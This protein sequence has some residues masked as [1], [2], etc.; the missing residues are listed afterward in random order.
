[1][2]QIITDYRT[3]EDTK[4]ELKKLGFSVIDTKPIKALYTEVEGHGDMQ[5]H[6][7]NGKA[8]CEPTVYNYYLKKLKNVDVIC[9][10]V[11]INGKYPEDIAYNTCAIGNTAV[12]K[13]SNTAPEIINEYKNII[14]TRQGYAKCSLCVL[15]DYSVITSDNGLYK[16]LTN[17]GFN[18]LK[19]NPGH[20]ALGS[21]EGFIG[22][23][24][25]L[26]K[27]NLIAFNGDISE[28]PDYKNIKCFCR[29]LNIDIIS[30]KKGVLTDIGS[31]LVV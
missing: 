22:G 20:I 17:L 23:A 25:G 13:V 2:K 3:D 28:H 5:I 6:I 19:I 29:D 26:I 31:F 21:M 10:S 9:G 16:Q 4:A 12:C 27:P 11:A 1:M 7:V 14:D 30:L 24:S 8:I 18:I 15:N